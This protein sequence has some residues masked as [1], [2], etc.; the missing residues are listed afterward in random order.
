MCGNR[1]KN[2]INLN[3]YCVEFNFTVSDFNVS[4]FNYI[5]NLYEPY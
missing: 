3:F 2:E 4:I 5:G 1:L